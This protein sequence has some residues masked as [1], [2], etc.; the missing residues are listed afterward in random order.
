MWGKAGTRGRGRQ[1]VCPSGQSSEFVSLPSFTSQLMRLRRRRRGLCWRTGCDERGDNV[2]RTKI[3][4]MCENNKMSLS[5]DYNTLANEHQVLAYFLPEAPSEM[6]KI[7]DEAAKEV[8]FS[9]FKNYERIVPYIHCRIS[10]L[11]LLEEL[12]SLRLVNKLLSHCG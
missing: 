8:V 2:Y 5:V 10:E 11:P 6:L 3:R 7:F 9:M 1:P 12:R 4:Q